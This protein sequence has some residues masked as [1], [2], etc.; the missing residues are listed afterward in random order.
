MEKRY[1]SRC[2]Y[3]N[4]IQSDFKAS[5][6]VLKKSGTSYRFR[7]ESALVVISMLLVLIFGVSS[8]R[9]HQPTVIEK[10]KIVYQT[11]DSIVYKD[12]TVY[13]PY[14]VVKDYS[15][16]TLVMKTSLAI[17]KSWVDTSTLYIVGELKN[18]KAFEVKYVEKE[19]LVVRDTTIYEEKPV[20]YP[21]VEEKKVIPT[22]A[23][24]CIIWSILSIVLL[25]VW[26]YLK[27][28]PF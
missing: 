6:S 5:G 15:L 16:D 13:V 19:K 20:P 18:L 1:Y 17:S 2:M 7:K 21:V 26:A 8:C 22:F 25:G 24:I 4:Y 14:E 27:F 11:K 9:T 23:W 10:E 12:S 3:G 28:K